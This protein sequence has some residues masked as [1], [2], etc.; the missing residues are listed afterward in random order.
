MIALDSDE[1]DESAAT[2][3]ADNASPM[4]AETV[5][6][7]SLDDE[8]GGLLEA[9]PAGVADT[10]PAGTVALGASARDAVEAQYSIWNVLS[11]FAIACLLGV[12]GIMMVD[13]NQN[14]WSWENDLAFQSTLMES[15]L[16]MFGSSS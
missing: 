16:K 14:I 7:E 6:F 8:G 4:D 5:D 9:A 12:I 2:M 13:L 10:V 15:I 3:L 1:F 11:L